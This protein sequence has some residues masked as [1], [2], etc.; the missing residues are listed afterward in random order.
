MS[1]SSFALQVIF[2]DNHYIAVNKPSGALVHGDGSDAP[3]L[4]DDVKAYIKLRYN[5]PGDVFLGVAHRLDRPVSG[6]VVYARTSKGLERLNEM[7]KERSVKKTYWALTDKLPP[8]QED[9]LTHW[10]IKD[11][12]INKSRVYD[13]KP[14]KHAEL[15]KEAIL[16]YTMMSHYAGLYLLQIEL[17]TGR[18]HQIRAQLAHIGCPIVGDVKYG[19]QRLVSDQSIALHCREMS[20]MHPVKKEPVV[21]TANP[22]KTNEWELSQWKHVKMDD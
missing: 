22:P 19:S 6:V 7:L 10:M 8:E 21:I 13:K 1:K 3:V 17:E 14:K 18:S 20:F 16:R 2:E 4:S 11:T 5:K 15:A 12:T 9:T